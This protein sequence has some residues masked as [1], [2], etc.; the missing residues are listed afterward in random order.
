MAKTAQDVITKALRRLNVIGRSETADGDI[1]AEALED[2]EVFHNWGRAEYPRNWSWNYDAVDDRY[3][4]HVAGMF[5]GRI[6]LTLPVSES[7][8]QRA[9][10]NAAEARRL[11]NQQFR[12]N[13]KQKMP[14]FL[15]WANGRYRGR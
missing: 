8:R 13:K 3:W 12:H 4:T 7:S 15:A 9:I 14:A 10:A 11:L 1:Y 2:Y 5:A 6:A